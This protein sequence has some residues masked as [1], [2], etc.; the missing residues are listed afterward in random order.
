M[1][2]PRRTL[3]VLGASPDQLFLIRTAR[4]MG[5]SVLAV[6]QNPDSPGFALAD[7]CAAISTRNVP[8][9]CSFLARRRAQDLDL[10]G[11]ITM[12]SDIPDVVSALA[13]HLG[14]PG[15][16]SE[17]ARLATDKFA[18]KTRLAESGIP[19][20]WFAEVRTLGEL[21]RIAAQRGPR[22]VLKPVD[23]SGSRGV[24]LLDERSD[25]AQLFARSRDFSYQG[26][27]LVEEYLEG[28]Q[29]STET[30]LHGGRAATPGL[31]DRNYE[32]LERFRPQVMENGAWVPSSLSSEQRAA[33][34]NV[35]VRAARALGIESGVAK[36]D[37]VWTAEGPKVIEI[38]ARLSGGDFCESLVPLGTGVNYVRSAIQLAIG[39]EPDWKALVPRFERA[40]ANRYFF[41]EPGEL[42]R[43]EG[44]EDVRAQPWV[45]KLELWYRPGQILPPI[46]S[47]AQR[48][49]VFVLTAPDRSTLEQ[50][51]RWVYG[52]I[53]IETRRHAGAAA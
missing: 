7:E 1:G 53:R 40:V 18:M 47:H 5:L 42:V 9:L 25:L 27:V 16:A 28:P 11:V 2:D 19:I 10:A 26:R 48:F 41:P 12:G 32:L 35:A 23:R 33:V 52:T 49:G 38:A 50:R 20:P 4:S 46:S 15:L 30:I 13:A 44:A 39:E 22:L 8:A 43:V 31:A 6:D 45:E 24:F 14:L 34:E 17:T 36:G 3:V 37:V 29:L 51:I 21:R